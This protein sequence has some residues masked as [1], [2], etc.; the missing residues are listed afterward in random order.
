MMLTCLPLALLFIIG[1]VPFTQGQRVTSSSEQTTRTLRSLS[2]YD[3]Y[4][5]YD[6][7]E[8]G[9]DCNND[10]DCKDKLVC[11]HRDADVKGKGKGGGSDYYGGPRDTIPGCPAIKPA[12]PYDDYCIDPFKFP[13]KTLWYV[14]SG[15]KPSFI[16]P[17]PECWGDCDND[18]HW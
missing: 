17:L 9:S 6:I 1:K 13:A 12:S 16:Y 2:P 4:C 11:F 7:G 8:C 14:G 10:C 15:D 5:N 18:S 3:R